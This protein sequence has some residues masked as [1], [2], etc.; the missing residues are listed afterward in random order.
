M[1]CRDL[2]KTRS[3]ERFPRNSRN[4][5]FERVRARRKLAL[6]RKALAEGRNREAF[7]ATPDCD[8]AWIKIYLKQG[9]RRWRKNGATQGHP[10][11]RERYRDNIA[12]YR[13]SLARENFRDVPELFQVLAAKCSELNMIALGWRSDEPWCALEESNID[14]RS[15]LASCQE[16][17]GER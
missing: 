3:V 9:N 14:R 6:I 15:G 2:R 10:V 8:R 1:I 16:G 17:E 5:A 7:P 12:R 4:R 11:T 13:C